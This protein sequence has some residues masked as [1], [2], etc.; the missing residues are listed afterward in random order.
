MN[1][2]KL[3]DLP[4]K[5]YTYSIAFLWSLLIFVMSIWNY[6]D[7]MDTA[8]KI[9]QNVARSHFNKNQAN[10]YWATEHSGVYIATSEKSP[11]SPNL[12]HTPGSDIESVTGKNLTSMNPANMKQ[13]LDE[14]FSDTDYIRGH[15]TSLK[16]LRSENKPDPWEE[17]ALLQFESGSLE[18]IEYSDIDGKNNIRLMKPLVVKKSCLECH[19]H[20][21]YKVGDI[22]G[23]VSVS[24]PTELYF[25]DAYEHINEEM[26]FFVLLWIVGISLIGFGSHNI[27]KSISSQRMAENK[28]C[29]NEERLSHALSV[30]NDGIWDWNLQTNQLEFD[31]PYYEMAG[32]DPNEFPANFNE[33]KK[34]VHQDDTIK[35]KNRIDEY[36][37]GTKSHYNMEYRFRKKNGEYMWILSK[38]KIVVYSDSGEPVRFVGTNSDIT[39]RKI[40]T[41]KLM[42]STKDTKQMN[43]LMIGREERVIELKKEINSLLKKIGENEKYASVE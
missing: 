20:Q 25:N 31:S 39:K 18:V 7:S 30:A 27:I 21:G 40:A 19:A 33:W 8:E 13:Q 2:K 23:G 37:N 4:V 35:F 5:K 11:P 26:I 3:T 12:S 10:R 24:I 41:E 15:L 38:G 43:D 9:V 16:P 34:R 36:L 32:Y 29:E 6:Q 14:D 1:N 28:L 22:R 42:E 17:M